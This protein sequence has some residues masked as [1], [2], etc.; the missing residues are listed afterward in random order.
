MSDNNIIDEIATDFVKM[1][2]KRDLA[3]VIIRSVVKPRPSGRG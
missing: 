3:A 2:Q 1:C